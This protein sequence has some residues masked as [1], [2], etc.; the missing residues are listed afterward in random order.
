MR[1]ADRLVKA[2]P[3]CAGCSQRSSNR[4]NAMAEVL[5]RWHGLD[6]RAAVVAASFACTGCV[7]AQYERLIN[8]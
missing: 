8:R 7:A 1:S 4:V 2:A 3:A 5:R 6:H